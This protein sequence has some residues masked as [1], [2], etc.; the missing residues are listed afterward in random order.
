MAKKGKKEGDSLGD[1]HFPSYVFEDYST[2]I[3]SFKKPSFKAHNERQKTERVNRALI[4][5]IKSAPDNVFLLFAVVDYIDRINQEKIIDAYTFSSFE[6]WLNQFSGLSFENNYHIR[7][8][9]VGK[10]VPRE[11]YQVLFP[12][13]MGKVYPGTHYVTAHGSP[14]LDTTIA[15]FWG[16]IDAFG[17]RVGDGLHLW[18]VPGGVP[19][20]QV[21]IPLLFNKFFGEK[22]FDYIV[23]GR[24]SLTLS[25]ID[26]MSQKGVL[27]KHTDESSLSIEH[28][29]DHKAVVLIDKRGYYLGDWRNFDVEG[30]RQVIMLLNNCMRWYE[31][32]L[33]VELISL[34]AQEELTKEK[35]NHFIKVAFDVRIG[36]SEP[37]REFTDTQRKYV[38]SYLIKVLGVTKGLKS[39]FEEFASSMEGVAIFDFQEFFHLVRSMPTSSLFSTKG[40]LIE[41]RPKIFHYLEKIIRALDKAIMNVRGHVD[42]L[43]VAL[44]IKMQVFGYMP[45]VVSYRADIEEIRNKMGSYPYLTVTYTDPKGRLLPIGVIR[46]AE[47]HKPI[48][49]TVSL[50]DFCN[51]EETKIPSYLEVI[52]V[53]DH[54]RTTLNTSSAPMV[55]ITDSQS[56]NALVAELAFTINDRYSTNGMSLKEIQKQISVVQ[57]DLSKSTNRRVLQRLLQRQCAAEKKGGFSI[58]P[59]REYVEYLHFLFAILDDTDLLS[60]VTRRD[61]ECM[62]SLLNRLK[63]LSIGEEAEIVSFDHIKG[64]ENFLIRASEAILQ[65]GDMYSLYRKVYLAKEK[66]IEENLK[67]CAA[68][69]ES[70]VFADTK[71]LNGCSSI[72]Q[73]KMFMHNFPIFNEHV[74]AIRAM[75]LKQAQSLNRERSEIDLYLHMVTTL[76]GAEDLYSGAKEEYK[77]RDQIWIWIPTKSLAIAHLKSFLNSFS[78]LPQFQEDDSLEVEFCGDNAL[79]LKQVFNESFIDIKQTNSLGKNLSIA[80]LYFKAGAINSR[81]AMISPFLPKLVS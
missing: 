11:E 29:R 1:F 51:R 75:W 2:L 56:S 53:I 63:S 43:D 60:K 37:A 24:G 46:A 68:G 66:A 26:L 19:E 81:K 59:Q 58:D 18:N 41:N 31:N 40:E 10:I 27:R 12:I 73:T 62:A 3:E 30:V 71:E 4:D 48:L 50:R 9:I 67:L 47:I 44:D 32:F 22:F 28:E 6:L 34:F 70:S 38:E 42:R 25:S 79:I 33:H 65:N 55:M 80:V 35:F 39:T 57:K 49:G 5:M 77:H 78:S 20:S 61:L 13:G 15:S 8:K 64:D 76:P 52:S 17:A 72:G 23:K 45:R 14:D 54:H 21:E 74:D 69:K 36:Q 7:A 16:W